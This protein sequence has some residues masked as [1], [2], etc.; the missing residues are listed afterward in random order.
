[1]AGK[2]FI[3]SVVAAEPLW[4]WRTIGG[5][6]MV[7]SHLCFAWNVFLMR[8]RRATSAGGATVTSEAAA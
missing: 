7:A 2:P 4:L 3:D 6:L 8:P 1:V 5:L